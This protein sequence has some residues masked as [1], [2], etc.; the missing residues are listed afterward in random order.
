MWICEEYHLGNHHLS[1]AALFTICFWFDLCMLLF[2]ILSKNKISY[3]LKFGRSHHHC[4][5]RVRPA[6][7]NQLD[8]SVAQKLLSS[9]PTSGPH[10]LLAQCFGH[11]GK[12]VGDCDGER[13]NRWKNDDSSKKKAPKPTSQSRSKVSPT[14]RFQPGVYL[15]LIWGFDL[16]FSSDFFH[17]PQTCIEKCKNWPWRPAQ[18]GAESLE[19][20][21]TLHPLVRAPPCHHPHHPC[22][23]PFP[24]P[25]S[26]SW[27]SHQLWRK[28]IPLK[29][30]SINPCSPQFFFD[31]SIWAVYICKT[32]YF[33]PK[34]NFEWFS[35]ETKV[36]H[37]LHQSRQ[38]LNGRSA[39]DGVPGIRGTAGG[40][41]GARWREY[42]VNLTTS[43]LDIFS[44]LEG[45]Q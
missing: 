12:D 22:W 30:P 19:G 25:T 2:L 37:C 16:I 27:V 39:T 35:R 29:S 41:D 45:S 7:L 23:H 21:W 4:H 18:L 43:Q 14:H 13:G 33:R 40:W 9:K 6:I 42:H 11:L 32:P 3:R 36:W 28:E 10:N 31:V 26:I 17:T 15:M 20:V 1:A 44:I 38:Q 34:I 24:G 8:H 5:D